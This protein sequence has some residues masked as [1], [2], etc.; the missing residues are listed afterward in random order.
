MTTSLESLL[1]GIYNNEAS[2]EIEKTAEARLFDALS[3]EDAGVNPFE[4]LTLEELTKLAS[5]VDLEVQQPEVDEDGEMEKAAYEALGGQIMAHAA[6]QE[7]GLIKEALVQGLCRVCKEHPL[8]VQGSSICSSCL[9][10]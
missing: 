7:M 5:Q 2:P 9:Q 3:E 4:N 10:G 1:D 6:T 8:D